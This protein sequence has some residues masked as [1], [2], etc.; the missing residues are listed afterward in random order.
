M[1]SFQLAEGLEPKGDQ[2]KAIKAI[3]DGFT[4]ELQFQVLK[5]VTGSGK[6]FSVANI[7]EQL[8]LPTLVMAPNK[9]LAAQLCSDFRRYFPDN[10][11]EYFVS[12]YDYYQPEAYVPTTDTYIGKDFSINEEIEKMRH[13]TTH[14]LATRKDVI[15][16]ASVS[17]IFGLGPPES[18]RT[19][20]SIKKGLEINR[21]ELFRRLVA[22]QYERNDFELRRGVFRARGDTVEIFPPHSDVTTVRIEMFGNIIERITE[23]EYP[24]GKKVKEIDAFDIFP[25]THYLT[26]EENIA[27]IIERVFNE[28]DERLQYFRENDL[29]VEAQRLKERTRYDMEMLREVGY[30]SGI[31]NYAMYLSNRN[32]GER[33]FVLLDH[34][35]EEFL[36]VIDESHI[37]IPQIRGMYRGDRARK[38]TLVEYGFRLPSALENRP[39]KFSEFKQ[40]MKKVIFTSATPGPFELTNND[41][42]VEQIIRPTGLVDPEIIIKPIKNQVDVLI[43]EVVARTRMN[44]R[45]LITTLTK[46]MAE[47][48][49]QFLVEKGIKAEYLHSE[50]DTIDRVSILRDLRKGK[51]EAIV[52]I[53]LLREGLDLPEVSLVA[54]LDADKEGFLRS[55]RSLTQIIGR[56]SRNINGKVILFADRMTNSISRTVQEN[57]RRRRIQMRYNKKHDITPQTIKKSLEDITD[58]LTKLE[59]QTV[60]KA[61]EFRELG[62]SDLAVIIL[63]LKEQMKE[64]AEKLEFEKAAELRDLIREL[65]GA[66]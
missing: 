52:G 33:P 60:K 31:E 42:I 53:N 57:N 6:T 14:A 12:F 38:Q 50:I 2:P 26:K 44:E 55:E 62:E 43:D 54:I 41:L 47:D 63:E 11:V 35:P 37:T 28:L 9:T 18:Y 23:N 15:V 59:P 7:I 25:A 34:F 29:L 58:G 22:L 64:A 3:V 40:F 8:Q 45:A 39:L 66:D 49:A 27:N 30:C 19:I 21:R 65:E 20:L 10:A 4:R 51:T 13:S 1:S 17:S 16:V 32:F 46:R 36:M 5:G 24:S 48:L 56:A 61:K